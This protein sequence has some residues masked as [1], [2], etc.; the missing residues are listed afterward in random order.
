MSCRQ[1]GAG[2]RRRRRST[3]GPPRTW[4]RAPRLLACVSTARHV[5]CT[6]EARFEREA[7][8]RAARLALPPAPHCAFAAATG[9]AACAPPKRL[10]RRA[11]RH[12]RRGA[13]AGACGTTTT[14][15][16]YH[17][18]CMRSPRR[19]ERQCPGAAVRARQGRTCAAAAGTTSSRT[20][21]AA[22]SAASR[23]G[24]QTLSA[25]APALPPARTPGRCRSA[26]AAHARRPQHAS[27]PDAEGAEHSVCAARTIMARGCDA[28]RQRLCGA[29]AER[30]GAQWLTLALCGVR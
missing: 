23:A 3:R 1:G 26:R 22:A 21:A 4:K 29:A 6:V 11:A 10:L 8:Q 5:Y 24:A 15:R 28:A 18:R 27:A 7:A 9:A 16:H 20:S 14:E 19:R 13:C 25:S 30:R 17:A 2:R 12:V